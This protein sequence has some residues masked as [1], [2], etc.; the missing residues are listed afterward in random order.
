MSRRE[1]P[2][3][4]RGLEEHRAVQFRASLR[5]LD[6]Y[7]W[8]FH[9]AQDAVDRFPGH[10]HLKRIA[11]RFERREGQCQERLTAPAA[12]ARGRIL[13]APPGDYTNLDIRKAAHE[14]P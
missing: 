11:A 13:D 1:P 7:D 5:A 4:Q 10:F 3:Q 6:E 14:T 9:D 2:R 8:H 12:I